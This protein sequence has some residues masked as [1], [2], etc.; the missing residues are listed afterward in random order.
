MA[1]AFFIA[2]IT[3]AC[4]WWELRKSRTEKRAE[5][6]YNL[7]QGFTTDPDHL[8]MFYRLEYGDFKYQPSMHF[9]EEEV[10]LDKLLYVLDAISKLYQMGA[11]TRA[12]IRLFEYELI[13]VYKN[14]Q[15]QLY[16]MFLDDWFTSLNV[17]VEPFAAFRTLGA[18]LS[19]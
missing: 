12:E 18:Y 3:L 4:Y 7:I 15:I 13:R 19:R 1:G 8:E 6:L 11:I 9:S 16:L 5:F 10:K 14:E 17:H 2:A